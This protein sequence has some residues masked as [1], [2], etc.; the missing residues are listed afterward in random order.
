MI[1][2]RIDL[3]RAAPIVP[4][5]VRGIGHSAGVIAIG[6]VGRFVARIIARRE[7]HA[8]GTTETADPHRPLL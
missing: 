8:K 4:D 7:P 1:S 3:E 6:R 5:D 2:G